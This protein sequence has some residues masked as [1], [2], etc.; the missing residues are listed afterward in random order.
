MDYIKYKQIEEDLADFFRVCH[1]KHYTA[2]STLI[3]PGDSAD[4]LYYLREGSVTIVMENEEGEELIIA[5]LNQGDFLGEIGLFSDNA[6]RSVIVKAKTDCRT[7]EI[8]YQQLQS[9]YATSLKECYPKLLTLLAE[10]MARRLLSTTRKAS[11]LAFLDVTGRVAA[12]LK[13]LS[14]QPD[15]LKHEEG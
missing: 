5:H 9:L 14:A 15:A 7:E 4:T 12:A 1:S 10:N 13:E 2:K 11:E 6:D 3:R 8:S